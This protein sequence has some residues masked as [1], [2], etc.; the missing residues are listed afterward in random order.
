MAVI[1]PLLSMNAYLAG[2]QCCE[3]RSALVATPTSPIP[4]ARPSGA[5]LSDGI[6]VITGLVAKIGNDKIENV[7]IEKNVFFIVVIVYLLLL[8]YRIVESFLYAY[9]DLFHRQLFRYNDFTRFRHVVGSGRFY[10][11]L[12][13]IYARVNAEFADIPSDSF[14]AILYVCMNHASTEVI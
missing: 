7:R 10:I 1:P 3:L 11:Y 12:I 8:I 2:F 4:A 9:L 14:Y 13:Y 5:M 6:A